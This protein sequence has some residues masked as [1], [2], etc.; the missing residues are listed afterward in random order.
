MANNSEKK[1]N[2]IAVIDSISTRILPVNSNFTFSNSD[3]ALLSSILFAI[4][5]AECKIDKSNCIYWEDVEEWNKHRETREYDNHIQ[6]LLHYFSKIGTYDCEKF[7]CA[8]NGFHRVKLKCSERGYISFVM[9]SL[10][11]N[12]KYLE[13]FFLLNSNQNAPKFFIV[14]YDINNL[15]ERVEAIKFDV[16]NSKGKIVFSQDLIPVFNIVRDYVDSDS[17]KNNLIKSFK[18]RIHQFN[19][20][21]E[22]TND[23][24]S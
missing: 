16:P 11:K 14:R 6:R 21:E 15:T 5:I 2:Q 18:D 20:L 9:H 8:D 22:N 1:Q 24:D 17:D 12:T 19:K 13:P 4:A 3:D 23:K 10:N 7:K